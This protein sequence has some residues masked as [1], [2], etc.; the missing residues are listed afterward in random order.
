MYHDLRRE[1][2]ERLVEMDQTG[3][4]FGGYAIGGLSDNDLICAA[5]IDQIPT[6]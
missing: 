5:K 2:V 3:S 4:G 6:R 1:S